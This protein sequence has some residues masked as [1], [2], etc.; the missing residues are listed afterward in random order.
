MSELTMP[1]LTIRRMAADD[2]GIALEWARQ[3]GWNPGIHDHET[4][5]MADPQG[6]FVGLVN[7]QPVAVG[8]AVRYGKD[9]AFCGLYIVH[10]EHRGCG[11]GMALT[12][13]RLEY[14]GERCT[15]IDGVL[16]NVVIYQRIGYRKAHE[17]ARYQFTAG[18]RGTA[19]SRLVP[20][21][22]VP[23]GKILD[24][25]RRCFPGPRDG[26]LRA[27]IEQPDSQGIAS[28]RDGE[29]AGYAVR[30][31]CHEGHK[32]GPLFAD[33]L[34]TA[35]GLLDACQLGVEGELLIVDLVENQPGALVLAQEFGME[36]TFATARMYRNGQ[37]DVAMERVFG[38]TTFEL[39]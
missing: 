10:P 30:R 4:F 34:Q 7:D 38:I 5:F 27:W 26:F 39:G 13:E 20:L 15:G 3:E 31:R 9:Y 29:V 2:V 16:E 1:E 32:I 8:S 6:F 17:N 23:F 14:C 33:D 24:Y 28:V 22:S 12:Q 35:R 37:P 11:Y 19:D 21:A 25:D 36:Q 18:D